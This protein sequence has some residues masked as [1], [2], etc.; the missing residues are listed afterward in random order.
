MKSNK[1]YQR[2]QSV[3][4]YLM[5]FSAALVLLTSVTLTQ[6]ILPSS[7]AAEKSLYLM[8]ADA[9]ADSIAGA[10]NT[11][12]ANGQGSVRSLLVNVDCGWSLQLDNVKNVVRM[13]I[14]TSGVMENLEK[15]VEYRI[16]YQHSL[17]KIAPGVYTV[18]VEWRNDK[19]SPEA[20]YL[21]SSDSKKI[22]L[23]LVG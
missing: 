19:N 13:M 10:I 4:E 1:S 16:L 7:E 11:V 17:P 14:W 15:E 6:M 5:I 18:I 2:G 23:N 9:A 3:V 21:D 22:H 20:M 12:Y 8:Q